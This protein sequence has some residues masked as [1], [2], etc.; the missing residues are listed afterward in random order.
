MATVHKPPGFRAE[1]CAPFAASKYPFR[2][3][4][5]VKP[6]TQTKKK[7]WEVPVG[8]NRSSPRPTAASFRAFEKRTVQRL[9]RTPG[10]FLAGTRE[11]VPIC[12]RGHKLRQ[13]QL[14]TRAFSA[15]TLEK[16]FKR[17]LYGHGRMYQFLHNFEQSPLCTGLGRESCAPI[18]MALTASGYEAYS[19]MITTG[20]PGFFLQP[21]VM[22]GH[23]LRAG[24][25]QRVSGQNPLCVYARVP[26]RHLLLS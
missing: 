4:A 19:V 20:I 10:P 24:V 16:P 7:G 22:T 15:V 21:C 9:G 14:L 6:L 26:R 8:S 12:Q 25:H 13:M 1:R 17:M 18:F 5:P 2:R 11:S 23:P 3:S